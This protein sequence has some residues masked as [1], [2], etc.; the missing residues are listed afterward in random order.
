MIT[1]D[2]PGIYI[3]GGY[4]IRL[5]NEL[6]CRKGEK[7]AYGQF[8]YF[9]NLTFVPFDLDAVDASQMNETEKGYLNAYHKAV[10]EKI[11]PRLTT[12]EAEWLKKY[13]QSI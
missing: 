1:T 7:N 11:A 2:E 10:Y 5:E 6:V 13:T 4:G 12:E 3:E 9:E 8:M